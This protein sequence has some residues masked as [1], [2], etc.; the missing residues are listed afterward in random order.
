M[1]LFRTNFM[2]SMT[3]ANILKKSHRIIVVFLG[4]TTITKETFEGDKMSNCFGNRQQYQGCHHE[5]KICA[6]PCHVIQRASHHYLKP[7]NMHQIILIHFLRIKILRLTKT[8]HLFNIHNT[9]QII[10][11]L[12]DRIHCKVNMRCIYQKMSENYKFCQVLHFLLLW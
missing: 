8:K 5:K 4:I 9:L 12:Y 10:Q 3:A 2:S 7:R 6:W 11:K 1:T